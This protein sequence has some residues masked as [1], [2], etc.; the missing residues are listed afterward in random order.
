MNTAPCTDQK[1]QAILKFGDLETY[2]Q[3]NKQTH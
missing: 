3:R 2:R 1:I